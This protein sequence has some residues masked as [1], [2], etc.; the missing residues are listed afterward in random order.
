MLDEMSPGGFVANSPC[1]HKVVADVAAKV[2]I[3]IVNI[4]IVGGCS[5]SRVVVVL[6]LQLA[7]AQRLEL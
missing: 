6:V 1:S 2:G 5:S 3:L 7:R 4:V